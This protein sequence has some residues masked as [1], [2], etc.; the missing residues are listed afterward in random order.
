[1]RFNVAIDIF[2]GPLDLLLYLVRKHELDVVD[3]PIAL[4]TEQFLEHLAALKR[5]DV[6][7]VGDF[8]AMASHLIEIKARMVLPTGDEVA[9]E[10]E[11]PRHELVER[12]LAYKAY[13]DAA[14]ILEEKSHTWQQQYARVASDL[15]S[16][17]LDPA[18]Q[19]IHDAELW[20]LVSAFG[21]VMREH[22]AVR[23]SN[24]VYDDTPIEVYMQRIHARVAAGDRV[25]FRDLFQRDAHRSMLVGVFLALLELMRHHYIV[26]EQEEVFS[27]IAI[28][29]GPNR[30]PLDVSSIASYEHGKGLK[31]KPDD[32]SNA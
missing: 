11:D 15:P 32:S 1:M 5:I 8:I 31:A 17:R 20:D 2:R 7:A 9:D 6:D 18:E 30:G 3:I 27:E 28:V 16:R 4:V 23:P 22:D 26:A 25:R 10:L 19:P 29:P 12:L 24:I 13:R 14:S 21:R